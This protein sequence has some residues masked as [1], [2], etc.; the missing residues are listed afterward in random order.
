VGAS[1]HSHGLDD[2]VIDELVGDIFLLMV[3]ASPERE[4]GVGARGGVEAALIH[5]GDLLSSCEERVLPGGRIDMVLVEEVETE[6]QHWQD[7]EAEV[8]GAG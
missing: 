8:E 4:E 7:T 5:K 2:V 1:R 3:D 6:L